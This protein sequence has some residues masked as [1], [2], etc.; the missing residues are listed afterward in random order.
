MAKNWIKS[1]IKHPGALSKQAKDAHKSI[2]EFINHPPKNASATTM[3]R[4]ALAKTFRKMK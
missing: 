2:G 4:I 3:R 1:A